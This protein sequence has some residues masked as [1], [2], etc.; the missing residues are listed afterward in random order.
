[1]RNLAVPAQGL[2]LAFETDN[3]I[4]NLPFKEND[5]RNGGLV[6]AILATHARYKLRP[7]A[8]TVFIST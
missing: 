7:K 5:A 2:A 6:K 8:V 4:Q 1:M 3:T